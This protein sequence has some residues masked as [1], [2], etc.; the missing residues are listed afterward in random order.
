M[1]KLKETLRKISLRT[2]S[3]IA[4]I[5]A[6]LGFLF[7]WVGKESGE[8]YL[9]L[10]IVGLIVVILTLIYCLVVFRCPHCGRLLGTRI[11]P[12][13]CPHCGKSLEE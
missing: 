7:M 12:E 2:H 6:L 1:E 9:W 3:W 13:F 8:A 4:T 5:V 11:L 10:F